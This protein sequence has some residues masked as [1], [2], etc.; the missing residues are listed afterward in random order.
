MQK[1]IEGMSAGLLA[2]ASAAC[3]AAWNLRH[4]D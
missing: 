3:G 2:G 4:Q 1:T